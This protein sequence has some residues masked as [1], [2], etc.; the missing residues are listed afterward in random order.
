[1]DPRERAVL[2]AILAVTLGCAVHRAPADPPRGPFRFGKTHNPIQNVY[3]RQVK[4]GR[5]SVVGLAQKEADDPAFGCAM[6]T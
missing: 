2:A 5:E 4:G 1:M 3:V 6:A